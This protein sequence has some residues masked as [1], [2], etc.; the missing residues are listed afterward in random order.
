MAIKLLSVLQ[1]PVGCARLVRWE[2]RTGQHAASRRFHDARA[3]CVFTA[4]LLR[5]H[6]APEISGQ[7]T[8]RANVTPHLICSSLSSRM[9]VHAL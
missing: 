4:S 3:R 2:R 9:C 1:D 8:C 6:L 7:K 5:P